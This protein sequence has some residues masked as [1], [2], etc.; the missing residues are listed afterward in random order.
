MY[1]KIFKHKGMFD[2]R[3]KTV[4]GNKKKSITQA[5]Y[6]SRITWKLRL[7]YSKGKVRQD[8]C[9]LYNVTK[10]EK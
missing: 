1:L 3:F 2:L 9:R 7:M 5:A 6:T 10:Q 8:R 4:N